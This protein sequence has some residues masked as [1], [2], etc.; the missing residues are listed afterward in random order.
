VESVI[1]R[2][3]MPQ[4]PALLTGALLFCGF[5]FLLLVR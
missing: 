3:R 2:L 4:V 5:G 1:A